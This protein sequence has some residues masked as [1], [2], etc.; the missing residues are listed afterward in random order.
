MVRVT[1]ENFIM[2]ESS[3]VSIFWSRRIVRRV[4]EYHTVCDLE[5]INRIIDPR[6]KRLYIADVPRSQ[7]VS[8]RFSFGFKACRIGTVGT[9]KH[10]DV[11]KITMDGVLE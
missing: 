7:N 4:K 10:Q 6:K 5:M 8:Q 9:G 1:A 11:P 3:S 2:F